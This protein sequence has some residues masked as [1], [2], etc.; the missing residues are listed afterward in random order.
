MS[1]VCYSFFYGF[2]FAL[3]KE[4]C[5]VRIFFRKIRN[6]YNRS[7]VCKQDVHID[8]YNGRSNYESSS[9]LLQLLQREGK[10]NYFLLFTF[11]R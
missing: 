10:D 3:E 2:F 7:N 4:N 1:V 9:Y 8:I 5:H 11:H 6:D